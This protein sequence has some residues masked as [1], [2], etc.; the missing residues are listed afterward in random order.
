MIIS[1]MGYMGSGKTL[2]S[3]ELSIL[4]NF[5][6]FDLDTEISKQNNRSITEIFKEKGEIFF[7]KT[8][9]EVLEKILSS[10][11][12]IILSLGGGTP[13]YYN[14][15][16]SINEKTISVFL[17][18]NVKTLAQ[19]LSSEK[20]KRPLIQN[21]SN[22]DLPEFIAKHLFERNPFYNQAKITINTDNLSAREIAEEI[23]TQIKLIP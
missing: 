20:D 9:K 12:N 4:N 18:T 19:R 10:E 16:D 13:C 6:I 14:N 8:E 23:L 17:K 22:E 2:V 3:K 15:I 11:K 7:R 21:I 1:L 5:K